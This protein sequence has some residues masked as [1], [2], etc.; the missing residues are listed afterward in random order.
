MF[1]MDN[2]VGVEYIFMGHASGIGADT[3]WFDL[4]KPQTHVLVAKFVNIVKI[5]FDIPFPFI[6]RLYFKQ[7]VPDQGQFYVSGT[8]NTDCDTYCIG[9]ITDHIL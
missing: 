7:D 4:I 9:P 8:E 6:G 3:H 1:Y 2:P 5:L